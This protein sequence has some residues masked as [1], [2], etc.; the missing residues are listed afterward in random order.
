MQRADDSAVSPGRQP[1]SIPNSSLSELLN[2]LQA[3]RNGD[4]SVRL[5]GDWTGLDGKIADT[6][7]EIVAVERKDGERA[8][9]RRHG[10]RQ[11]GQDAPA[12]QVRPVERRVGRDGNV[13]QHADR[14]P[15]LA[16]D[17]SHARARRGGQG[18][19]AA[20]RPPGRGRPSARRRVPSIRHHRQHDDRAARRLH[21]RGDAR[22][23][24]GGHGRQAR[25]PGGS[26]ERER[27]L[28][29]PDRQRQLDGQQPDR[30]R[31]ATSPRSPSPSRAATS[32]ARSRSTCAARFCS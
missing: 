30:R 32:R 22:G 12:R 8:R 15:A 27:R 19:S 5:P 4:F 2:V 3:V 28:E 6:V 20:D 1:V 26:P 17:G 11:A 14:R 10:R 16:D 7:N 18:R 21:L 9:T 23:A 29:G 25:R 31:S 13:G 24:R